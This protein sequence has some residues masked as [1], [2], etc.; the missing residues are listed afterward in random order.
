[1]CFT[2]ISDAVLGQAD[3]LHE[4]EV[5]FRYAIEECTKYPCIKVKLEGDMREQVLD[6]VY[7][8]VET[9]LLHLLHRPISSYLAIICATEDA[10][11]NR[12]IRYNNEFD[13]NL[14]L[15]YAFKY[16]LRV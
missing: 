12:N 9:Y 15:V 1:M 16:I 7:A 3:F 14:M 8:A 10:T 13:T 2:N 5:T 4:L 6:N 11:Y